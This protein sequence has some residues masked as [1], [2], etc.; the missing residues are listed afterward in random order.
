MVR[1]KADKGEMDHVVL[2]YVEA[3]SFPSPLNPSP[4]H[5]KISSSPSSPKIYDIRKKVDIAYFEDR[6]K[7]REKREREEEK[8]HPNEKFSGKREILKSHQ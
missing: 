1:N 4:L 6:E 7:I 2:P 8:S 5:P 3:S